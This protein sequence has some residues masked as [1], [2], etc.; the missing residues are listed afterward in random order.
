MAKVDVVQAG[1]QSV[2]AAEAQALSDALGAFYD[3][4]VA[5]Q[6]AAGGGFTQADIDSAVAA[7]Q[8][9]D[10][11]TLSASQAADAAALA[12]AL[13]SDAAAAQT[14]LDASNASLASLQAAL[15]AMTAKDTADGAAL[16]AFQVNV[17]QA[18][19]NLTAI[20]A[21]FSAPPVSV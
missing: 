17:A 4:V 8:T 19:A 16:A 2:Q 20:E 3:S 7:A 9:A 11:A 14:A 10:A 6:P 13:A 5:D 21:L 18:Q 15:D 1:V 12:G